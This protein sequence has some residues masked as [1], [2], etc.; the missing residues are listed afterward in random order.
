MAEPIAPPPPGTIATR[1]SRRN[2]SSSLMRAPSRAGQPRRLVVLPYAARRTTVASV[3]PPRCIIDYR[4]YAT[5]ARIGQRSGRRVRARLPP[6][7]AARPGPSPLSSRHAPSAA[8]ARPF[9][10]AELLAV[11]SELTTGETRDTNGGELARELALRG[12]TVRRISALPDEL[13]LVTDAFVEALAG[14]D[15][16][17][18]TG[19]LG[20]T[21]DDLT[22]EAVAAA[23]GEEPAVDPEQERW[24]R[25]LFA[26]AWCPPAGAEPQAGV[27]DPVGDR[28][29]E[30]ERDGT[31]L[32]GRPPGRPGRR[33]PARAAAR[34]A[35]DVARLGRAAPRARAASATAG[36]SGRCARTA[37]ASRTSRS[38]SARRCSAARNPEVATYA[39]ADWLDI[40]VS[41]VDERGPDGAVARP[42]T[43][44]LDA[45]VTA[46]RDELEGFV[47]AEGETS[48]ADLVAGAADRAGVRL[49][50]VETGTNG[51]LGDLLGELP[52]LVRAVAVRPPGD[53]D[54]TAWPLDEEASAV[55]R[56]AG[57]E[58]GLALVAHA[59]GG[60]D[61]PARGGRRA[62]RGLAEDPGAAALPARGARAVQGRRGGS[63]V[64]GRNARRPRL[65][66]PRPAARSAARVPERAAPPARVGGGAEGA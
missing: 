23:V 40:R 18:A 58:V 49:A 45:A 14:V 17:V 25:D 24:L 53:P 65:S 39:R 33:A 7:P 16:V 57:V 44:L 12:V 41:A 29:P 13:V 47:R 21:P 20:P 26:R 3:A 35:A 38:S 52:V 51:A 11:G 4:E 34:D 9:H 61:A 46:V 2:F 59:D 10:T 8:F 43:E 63:G 31:R 28:D 27:A 50:I 1:P 66:V 36:S 42:A 48:W 32:V 60:A 56:D 15:L 19:G 37:S 6:V 5:R 64:P 54:V 30:P 22:R 55:A 62:S